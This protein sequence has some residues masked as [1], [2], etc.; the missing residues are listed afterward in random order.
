MSAKSLFEM[1]SVLW[2]T[3]AL[4]NGTRKSSKT[5]STDNLARHTNI[6]GSSHGTQSTSTCPALPTVYPFRSLEKTSSW[7]NSR[8]RLRY[9]VEEKFGEQNFRVLSE[10]RILGK[11]MVAILDFCRV[12][13][14]LVRN[15]ILGFTVQGN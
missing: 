10:M 15:L 8:Y 12:C 13:R 5:Q 6:G 1:S 11:I 9:Q 2:L 3:S 7:V 4:Y 14:N